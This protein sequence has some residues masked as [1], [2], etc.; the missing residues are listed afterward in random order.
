MKPQ[1]VR[2]KSLFDDEKSDFQY[3]KEELRKLRL[4]EIKEKEKKALLKYQE[5]LY[6]RKRG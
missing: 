5:E 1:I 2:Q 6:K 3:L 4:K